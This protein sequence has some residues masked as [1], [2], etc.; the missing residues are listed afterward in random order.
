MCDYLTMANNIHVAE[1]HMWRR[2]GIPWKLVVAVSLLVLSF[3][4]A[5]CGPKPVVDIKGW[6]SDE[7]K[8]AADSSQAGSADV[9]G[10]PAQ[11]LSTQ[12]NV[13]ATSTAPPATAQ[14]NEQFDVQRAMSHVSYLAGVI[15]PREE[16][17]AGE[18]QA[19]QYIRDRLVEYG[20]A[21]VIEEFPIRPTG[22]T[23]RNVTANLAGGQRPEYKVVVGAH[24][25]TKSK[26]G[27]CPGANDN[28]S[29]VAVLLELARVEAVNH[30]AVPTIEFVFFGAE[31]IAP[32][33]GGGDHHFGSTHYVEA[34]DPAGRNALIGMISVDM[35]GFGNSF[36][37]RNMKVAPQT[38]CDL[39]LQ[40]GGA[41]GMSYLK[42]TGS[43]GLSDHQPFEQAGVPSVWVEYRDD[44][45]IHGPGDT[46][47]HVDASLVLNTGNTLQRFFES[48]LTPERVE[49][50][51]G[52]SR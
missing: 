16:C 14:V 51:A 29:G 46:V 47:Q 17:T 11:P 41:G 24:M 4:A 31:E 50:L 40:C 49:M 21:P 7:G 32:G 8:S 34:M 19:A 6:P 48:Y 12:P 44:P 52:T 43:S 38:M 27:P 36:L 15:G 10:Q 25:D 23:S 2:W 26:S 37:A 5:G 42:D 1:K 20:Y 13:Q 39:L 33:G 18:Q 22:D 30:R 9:P 3:T 35:V 28:A 45:H